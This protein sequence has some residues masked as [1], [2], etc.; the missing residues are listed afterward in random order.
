MTPE[1]VAAAVRLGGRSGAE[2][3][4]ERLIPALTREQRVQVDY[5]TGALAESLVERGLGGV[6]G[7]VEKASAERREDSRATAEALGALVRALE[8]D[9]EEQVAALRAMLEAS[10]S[11][12]A[13][14]LDQFRALSAAAARAP[15][16]PVVNV[17]GARVEASPVP[18]TVN[19]DLSPVAPSLDRI[20][21]ALERR[22]RKLRIQRNAA[23]EISGLDIE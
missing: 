10:R 5:A 12:Y 3:L 16:A 9:R 15:E 4:A 19:V 8:A 18:V 6:V 17:E 23:G 13:D 7:V 21:T 22:P 11:L 2:A 1:E 14:L 20:A